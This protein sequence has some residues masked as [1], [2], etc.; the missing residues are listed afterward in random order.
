MRKILILFFLIPLVSLG[1]YKRGNSNFK[2]YKKN[3]NNYFKGSI[4]GKVIDSNTEEPLE[5]ASISLIN[6]RWNKIIEGTITDENG[7]FKMFG[8]LSG[9]YKIEVN[10]IGYE[11][12]ELEFELTKKKPD[13]KLDNLKLKVNSKVLSELILKEDKPIYESKIDKIVYNVD[14]DINQGT[15]DASDV[16]RKTPLLSVDFEGNVELRGS[17]NIKFLLNGKA[18]SFLSGDLSSALSMIPADQ[19]KSIE[20]ITSPGAKYDGEGEA[21]IVNIITK[22]TIIDGYKAT[23]DGSFGSRINKNGYNFNIGKGRFNISGRGGVNYSWEREGITNYYR[24]DWNENGDTNFLFNNGTST[25]Q[26][27]GYRGGINMYYDINAYNSISS[28]IS[29]NGRKTPSNNFTEY[30]YINGFNDSLSDYS[31]DSNVDS[32]RDVNRF[33]WNLDYIKTFDRE[34]EELSV[35]YQLGTKLRDEETNI[36]ENNNIISLLNNNDEK[37]I[38][39]T[40]QIDYI[41]PLRNN[42]FEFGGKLINRKQE[43]Q[44]STTSNNSEF[45]LPLEVFDYNQSVAATYISSKINISEEYNFLAGIRYELTKINGEWMNNSNNPFDTSYHNLLPNLT[46][47]KSFGLGKDIKL[48]YSTRIS[49][50]SSRYINTNTDITNN[51]NIEVGNPKLI[52]SSTQQIELGYN[53]FGRKYQ[54]SYYIYLKESKDIIESILTV[55]N[56]TSIT[57]YENI[58]Q[59]RRYG[60]NYYGSIRFKK[61]VL[62]GG[63]NI[64]L[65][66]SKDERFTE[67]SNV[68]SYSYNYGG[69]YDLGKNWKAEAFGWY[70]SPNQTLQGSSTSFHM[71]SFGVKKE[72]SNKRGSLGLRIIEPFLKDGYKVFKTDLRGSNFEQISE[73]KI[74]FTSI[75]VSFKYTF[76]KLN[77]KSKNKNI[78]IKNDDVNDS[79]NNEF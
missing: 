67:R 33:E 50:P 1:Q 9:K 37:N 30:R 17:K 32:E 52:P 19:I 79:E 25:S 69:S 59:N 66:N 68:T 10:Y 8:I 77:F 20:V 28:D 40:I 47:S 39:Q 15:D 4:S 31:Y 2:G 22:K 73:R 41:Y 14:N 55:S 12:G 71:M 49:R 24:K 61:L 63:F 21:G 56:D 43:M 58:G 38:D 72:F 53:S 6:T 60:F 5:F 44:Y 74:L 7:K 78:R 35:S 11:S 18:S 76:G 70:R 48:S 36:S 42:I 26:W 29:F 23:I 34:G 54:G 27:I 64:S 57:T 13:I 65:Y 3:K 75:G 16:L 62:R 46:I 45:I 51:K